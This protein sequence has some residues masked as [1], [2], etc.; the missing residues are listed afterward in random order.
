MRESAKAAIEEGLPCNNKECS[1]R[2]SCHRFYDPLR[3]EQKAFE[4][5]GKCYTFP[6]DD[7]QD[8][9]FVMRKQLEGTMD[10][11]RHFQHKAKNFLR[12]RNNKETPFKRNG[13]F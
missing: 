13:G 2:S 4:A 7:T 8:N 6:F 9:C 3:V 10:N 12:A 11:H 1:L 5:D